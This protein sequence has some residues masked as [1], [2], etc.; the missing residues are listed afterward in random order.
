MAAKKLP[1]GSW[2]A[3]IYDYTDSKGKEHYKSFTAST[4]SEAERMAAQYRTQKERYQNDDLT[5]AEA[6]DGFIKARKSILSPSTVKGYMY[7]QEKY[8]DPINHLRIG[9]LTTPV[10]Q[11]FVSDLAGDVSAKSVSN[12]YGL[13]SSSL[14]FYMPDRS[15]KVSL[16]KKVKKKPVSPSD[17]DVRRLFDISSESMRKCICLAA[18]GSLRRGEICAVTFGDLNGQWI[19]VHSDMVQKPDRSWVIKEIPKTKDGIRDVKLPQK[20]VEML[21]T[22]DPE[23]RILQILPS[24]ITKEFT[25]FRNRAGVH[26][27]FHDLRH[28]YASIGAALGIPDVYL[29]DFGGWSA[30]SKVMKEVYQNKI[31]PLSEKYADKMTDHFDELLKEKES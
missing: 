16:P 1:S 27:R 9:K 10:L 13:L 19:H 7:L 11:R 2:R 28:Y 14:S 30:G 22:G 29:A 21:G 6:I 31:I 23:E 15:F 18:F 24:T 17:E 26:I 20:V 12:I 25:K 3:T 4:K 5:V 8:Y